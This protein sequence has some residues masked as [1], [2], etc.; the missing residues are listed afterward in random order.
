MAKT[1]VIKRCEVKTEQGE[2]KSMVEVKFYM[3]RGE[4]LA[5]LNALENY[6]T[7]VAADVL[8]YLGNALRESCINPQ[9]ML[10]NT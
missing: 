1:K 8:A 10:R 7:V 2:H 9:T 5:L 6:D 3:T 4:T